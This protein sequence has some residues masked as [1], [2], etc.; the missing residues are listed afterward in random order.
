MLLV[1]CGGFGCICGLGWVGL[2]AEGGVFGVVVLGGGHFWSIC[3]LF[4]VYLWSICGSFVVSILGSIWVV[5]IAG[6]CI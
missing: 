4:V 2:V 3:G 6:A 1:V 5:G